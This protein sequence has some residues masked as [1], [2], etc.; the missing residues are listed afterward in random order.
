MI[1]SFIFQC[2][3]EQAAES[4]KTL[5]NNLSDAVLVLEKQNPI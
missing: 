5:F 3:A 2:Q 1:R 4:F